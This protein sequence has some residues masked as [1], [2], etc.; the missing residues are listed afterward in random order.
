MTATVSS[1]LAKGAPTSRGASRSSAP[2]VCTSCRA[3]G[4][5][6]EPRESRAGFKSIKSFARRCM[7]AHW[8]I[9]W[10]FDVQ[11]PIP[12]PLLQENAK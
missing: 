11:I 3:P 8:A 10:A 7:R 4:S 9:T 2:H 5:P 1:V 12:L 6:R